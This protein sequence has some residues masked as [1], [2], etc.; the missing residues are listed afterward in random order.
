MR[1]PLHKID[2]QLHRTIQRQLPLHLKK[3]RYGELKMMK[4]LQCGYGVD[5]IAGHVIGKRGLPLKAYVPCSGRPMV[6]VRTDLPFPL[7]KS[8][9]YVDRLLAY[10]E[11]GSIAAHPK[12]E[13]MFVNGD[14][15]DVRLSNLV[16]VANKGRTVIPAGSKLHFDNYGV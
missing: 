14:K 6:D 8:K 12:T 5:K 11:Y 13:I 3:I 4:V 2:Y 10:A 7:G 1:P 15:S 16:V 9:V